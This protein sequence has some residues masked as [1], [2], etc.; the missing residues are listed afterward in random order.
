MRLLSACLLLFVS[1]G[2]VSGRDTDDWID[3]TS[4]AGKFT[5]KVPSKPSEKKRDTDFQGETVTIHTFAVPVAKDGAYLV[6]YADFPED[7]F[8]EEN[9]KTFLE[10]Y[11]KGF[12]KGAKGKSLSSKAVKQ[13]KK[14]AGRE[15]TFAIP[16]LEGKGR[17]RV[18]VVGDR[19]YQVTAL[20]TED[21]MDSEDIDFFFNS[22]KVTVK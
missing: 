7:T 17:G 20:G 3:F 16:E 14:Y 19:L 15:F 21:F 9:T 22:F 2:L 18:F 1:A 6:S 12:V 11:E 13:Q 10:N 5:V 4:K 8:S